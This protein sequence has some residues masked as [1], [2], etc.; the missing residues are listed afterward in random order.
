MGCD[1]LK[2]IE[3]KDYFIIDE[4]GISIDFIILMSGDFGLE[5]LL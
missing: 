1:T 2:K 4:T 3:F 5:S